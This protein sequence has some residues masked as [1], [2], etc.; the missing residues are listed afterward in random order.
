MQNNGVSGGEEEG[1][2]KVKSR[3]GRRLSIVFDS[4]YIS[5]IN[6]FAHCTKLWS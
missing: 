3:S 5:G 4:I 1:V 6:A 2:V